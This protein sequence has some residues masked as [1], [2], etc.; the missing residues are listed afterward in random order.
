[1][2]AGRGERHKWKAAVRIIHLLEEEQEQ[3][4]EPE[5]EL[6]QGHHRTSGKV[7]LMADMGLVRMARNLEACQEHRMVRRLNLNL[8]LIP[9]PTWV[10]IHLHVLAPGPGKDRILHLEPRPTR[11]HPGKSKGG[12]P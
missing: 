8:E 9:V 7:V 1:M 3:E 6:D 10:L 4:P 12:D 5:P 11:N 2:R